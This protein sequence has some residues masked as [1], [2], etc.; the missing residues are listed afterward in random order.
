VS[1][2]YRDY[3]RLQ[4]ASRLQGDMQAKVE[5]QHVQAQ[6]EAVKT[7]WNSVFTLNAPS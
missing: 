2:A 3:R 1:D 4:H 7:L 6:A 5:Y